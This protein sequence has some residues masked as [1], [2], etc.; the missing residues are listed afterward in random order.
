MR[1][2]TLLLS[3]AGLAAGAHARG[4]TLRIIVAYPPGG[5]SDRIAR[6]FAL[7]L[8]PVIGGR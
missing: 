6:I 7:R 4:D 2:R 3:A 1:R 5:V 8:A